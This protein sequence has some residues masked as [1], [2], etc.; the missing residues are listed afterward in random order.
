MSS[1]AWLSVHS[2]RIFCLSDLLG[3]SFSFLSLRSM[4]LAS[5]HGHLEAV[6]YL[7]KQSPFPTETIN[8][9]NPEGK[10][11]LHQAVRNGHP[12][13][14]GFILGCGGD[15][16]AEDLCGNTPLHE[17]AEG[18]R[19]EDIAP[20]LMMGCKIDTLN[21]LGETPLQR[22]LWSANWVAAKMLVV[23]GADVNRPWPSLYDECNGEQFERAKGMLL[24]LMH[25][26]CSSPIVR[27]IGRM[28]RLA[29]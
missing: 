28:S 11:P 5:E 3:L 10:T 4:H 9:R 16:N 21:G 24:R 15:A 13:V 27:Q 8:I 22:A 25:W 1:T 2:F 6:K 20:L 17:M 19:S 26:R 7:L 23:H 29:I 18:L 14:V 12:D